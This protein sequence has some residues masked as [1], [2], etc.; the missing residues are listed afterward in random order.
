MPPQW[1]QDIQNEHHFAYC[2]TE[3]FHSPHATVPCETQLLVTTLGKW[4]E[5]SGTAGAEE[6]SEVSDGLVAR[7]CQLLYEET[8]THVLQYAAEFWE[9]ISSVI[10]EKK[11]ILAAYWRD[12]GCEDVGRAV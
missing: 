12:S 1:V 3:S 5:G 10:W 7:S 9:L 6:K 8:R 4:V 2:L 11:K